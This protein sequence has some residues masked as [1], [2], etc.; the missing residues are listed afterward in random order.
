MVFLGTLVWMVA[1]L[2]L[3]RQQQYRRSCG[4]D[5]ERLRGSNAT[6]VD[7][8][9]GEAP[10]L[11]VRM[12]VVPIHSKIEIEHVPVDFLPGMRHDR[13]RIAHEGATVEAIGGQVVPTRL[14]DTVLT[15]ATVGPNDLSSDPDSDARRIESEV[16]DRNARCARATGLHSH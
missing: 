11:C 3:L 4:L 14:D 16:D 1:V 8:L 5:H 12:K 6:R 13:R 10:A 15:W 2:E 7:H 9:I